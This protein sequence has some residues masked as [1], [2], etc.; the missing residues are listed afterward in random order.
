L[1]SIHSGFEQDNAKDS[2]IEIGT[3]NIGKVKIV[4]NPTVFL[5]SGIDAADIDSKRNSVYFY[6]PINDSNFYLTGRYQRERRHVWTYTFLPA[7]SIVRVSRRE[8][9]LELG[10]GG[11]YEVNSQYSIYADLSKVHFIY[12]VPGA[13]DQLKTPDMT[14]ENGTKNKVGLKVSIGD[15]AQIDISRSVYSGF[16]FEAF[17][18]NNSIKLVKDITS[19]LSLGYERQ[20][21]YFNRGDSKLERINQS[22]FFKEEILMTF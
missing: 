10:I 13:L 17:S 16:P 9:L 12:P 11:T 19:D 22:L 18:D 21:E 20:T 7:L 3:T 15:D 4:K 5:Q 2:Y 14:S 1:I 8:D 6:K